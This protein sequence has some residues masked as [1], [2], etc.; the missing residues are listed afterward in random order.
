MVA[1]ERGQ[2]IHAW[3]M[4]KRRRGEKPKGGGGGRFFWSLFEPWEKE[5]KTL[6]KEVL[7]MLSTCSIVAMLWVVGD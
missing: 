5:N 7:V 4:V 2:H 6:G 1:S 3:K